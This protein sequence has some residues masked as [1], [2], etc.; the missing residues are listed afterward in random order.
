[1]V[2]AFFSAILEAA[3]SLPA[4]VVLAIIGLLVSLFVTLVNKFFTNQKIL[5]KLKD[6]I[7]EIRGSI[8]EF[9]HDASKLG[10]LNRQIIY[11]NSEQ[12][13]HSLRSL[14]FTMIPLLLL[15]TWMHSHV[16]LENVEPGDAFSVTVEKD[17]RVFEEVMVSVSVENAVLLS[18]DNDTANKTIS[19]GLVSSTEIWRFMALEQDTESI[20]IISYVI[21]DEENYTQEVLITPEWNYNDPVLEKDKKF[22]G[23]R[24][25]AGD[26][27][28]S[29]PISRITV[30]LEPVRPFGGF[31]LFG[32]NPGWLFTYIFFTLIFSILLR[33]LF[34][35]H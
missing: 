27:L 17:G 28:P 25:A 14:F 15:V 21:N 33:K 9:K 5:K 10:E 11:K 20:A 19:D 31:T 30:N 32:W 1:M 4:V 2:T 12:M 22:L 29:S 6:E 34:N 23:I 8:K 18:D 24:Y 7:K 13:R 3:L 35:V 26:I 16:A